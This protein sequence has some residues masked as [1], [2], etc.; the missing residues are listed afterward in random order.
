[1]KKQLVSGVHNDRYNID[2]YDDGTL[3]I[4]DHVEDKTITSF[5]RETVEV[6]LQGIFSTKMKQREVDLALAYIE[7]SGLTENYEGWKAL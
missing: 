4:Y 1:M 3:T 6:L 7:D 5:D 2:I